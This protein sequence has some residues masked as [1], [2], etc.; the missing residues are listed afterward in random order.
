MV[1]VIT[2]IIGGIVAVFIKM[3]VQGYIDTARRAGM[4]DIADT[5]LRR[6]SRDIRTALPNSVRITVVGADTYLEFIPV[7]GSGRYRVGV[8]TPAT[9]NPLNFT[10]AD[11][12]FDVLGPMPALVT[13]DTLVIYNR[14]I[15]T[16]ADAYDGTSSS[17]YVTPLPVCT[18]ETVST[19]ATIGITAKQFPFQSPGNRFQVIDTP[20]TYVCAPATDGAGNGTGTLTRYWGYAIQP[21]QPTA[22]A[23]LTS[24][25]PPA[26]LASKVSACSF[27][28]GAV[29]QR[30]SLVTMNL[31]ITESGETV[32]LYSATH[33]SNVP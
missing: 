4:T 9:D 6:M 18:P 22:L 33:V 10:V 21:G 17:A 19:A 11:N 7:K 25:N 16:V 20:V 24:V 2:G 26:L 23:T 8:V 27:S 3:P 14:G 28:Y 5:A 12:C 31:G 32:T 1:I 13:G 30:L 29:G 15:P